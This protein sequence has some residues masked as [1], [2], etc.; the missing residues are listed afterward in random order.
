MYR[1]EYTATGKDNKGKYTRDGFYTTDDIRVTQPSIARQNALRTAK[2]QDK[3][4]KSVKNLNITVKAQDFMRAN[5]IAVV[6][7]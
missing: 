3:N 4:V 6:N 5:G 2:L 1:V 7:I